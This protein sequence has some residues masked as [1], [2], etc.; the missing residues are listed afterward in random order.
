ME[1]IEN[2]KKLSKENIY[3]DHPTVVASISV[4][5]LLRGL[6][7]SDFTKYKIYFQLSLLPYVLVYIIG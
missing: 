3:A 7:N 4:L 2:A 5:N 6:C 1:A